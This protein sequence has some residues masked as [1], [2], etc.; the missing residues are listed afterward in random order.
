[1]RITGAGKVWF[2]VRTNIK[3]EEKATDNLRAAGFEVYLP[4]MRKDIVH[5]RTKCI[6]TR[7][8]PLFNRYLFVGMPLDRSQQ[9]F[10]FVRACEGVECILGSGGVYLPVPVRAID[11]FMAAEMDMQF[12]DTRA[13]KIHRGEIEANT[14][15]QYRKMFPKGSS[16]LVKESAKFGGFY[17]EVQSVSGR[18]KVTAMLRL[19]NGLV[20]VE[21]EAGDLI[22]INNAA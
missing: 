13:A 14:R 20:P 5:H 15:A 21:F 3:C 16:F 22:S 11:D 4:R 12:D 2:V 6:I 8:F 10:G 17:G 9:H 1:M 19:F 7:E 18:G